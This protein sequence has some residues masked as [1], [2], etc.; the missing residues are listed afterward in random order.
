MSIIDVIFIIISNFNCLILCIMT[1]IVVLSYLHIVLNIY[2]CKHNYCIFLFHMLY[3]NMGFWRG[4]IRLRIRSKI[5]K[6]SRCRILQTLS[7]YQG[8]PSAKFLTISQGCPIPSGSLSLKKPGSLDMQRYPIR[9]WNSKSR[10]SAPFLSLSPGLTPL[11]LDQ[12]HTPYGP[13]A[14]QF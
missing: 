9:W 8:W 14:F 12:H 11:F 6:K 3:L 5:W 7:T 4:S 10:A 2:I 13:G 1:Y